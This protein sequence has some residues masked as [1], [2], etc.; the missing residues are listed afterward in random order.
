MGHYY[1][2]M[3]SD[4]RTPEQ[5]KEDNK[6]Q[7]RREQLEKKICELFECKPKEMKIV[8]DILKESWKM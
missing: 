5:I 8:Y 2:E 4:D 6:K 3:Y 1:S 7:K